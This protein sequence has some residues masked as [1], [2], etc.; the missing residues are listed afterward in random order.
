V[1]FFEVAKVVTSHHKQLK[2]KA[3]K[4]RI[5]LLAAVIAGFSSC[6]TYRSGQTPDDVYYSPARE[7]DGYVET[8]RE[9]DG[10]TSYNSSRLEDQRLRQQIRDQRF[11]SFD[12][13]FYWNNPRFSS[14]WG[15]N[16]WNSPNSWNTWG[17]G[18]NTWS[19]G[20][21]NWNAWNNPWGWNSWNS[22]FV[23]VPGTTIIIPGPGA[24]KNSQGIRYS[25]PVQNFS[26][27]KTDRGG[28][29]GSYSSGSNGG[30]YFG[31][32]TNNTNR[33]SS[34]FSDFFGGSSNSGTSS[35]SRVFGSGSSGGSRIFSSGSSGS[36]GSSSG[37]GKSSGGTG[38]RRN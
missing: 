27:T 32:A 35:G 18:W 19:L 1:L 11:R 4:S 26:N 34:F 14:S 24:P 37:G 15:W 31:G 21:N 6:A 10:R 9:D 30:R 29:F 16:S 2:H 17:S 25:P 7:V 12:D 20:W 23:C 13:D 22:P 5:V 3:M 28:K 33:R 8:S 36:S 38:G